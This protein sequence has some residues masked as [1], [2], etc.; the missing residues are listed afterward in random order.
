MRQR[1]IPRQLEHLVSKTVRHYLNCGEKMQRFIDRTNWIKGR[2]G[3]YVFQL[4]HGTQQIKL[5][6]PKKYKNDVNTPLRVR[7]RTIMKIA[8]ANPEPS[9]EEKIRYLLR[10]YPYNL[11][12]DKPINLRL[13]NFYF[14]I[15]VSNGET[16]SIYKKRA[17][18]E[19]DPDLDELYDTVEYK[20][21][22]TVVFAYQDDDEEYYYA[23]IARTGKISNLLHFIWD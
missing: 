2:W 17:N 4:S 5:Y 20:R 14:D 23:V 7:V 10:T 18:G 16:L 13:L 9:K 8:S 19:P 12:K 3:K 1:K 6:E 21:K 22:E 15:R 11:K